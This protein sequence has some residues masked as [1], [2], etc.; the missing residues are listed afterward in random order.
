MIE[1]L[2]LLLL[3]MMMMTIDVMG[4]AFCRLRVG[5]NH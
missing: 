5:D 4:L 1:M 3:L 2:L